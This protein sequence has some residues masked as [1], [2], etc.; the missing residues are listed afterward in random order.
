M[1]KQLIHNGIVIPE[2][3]LPFYLELSIRGKRRQL[4]LRQIE[5]ALAWAR[6]HGTPY[7]EDSTFVC[8]YMQDFSA[9]LGIN[10]PL[11]VDEVDFSPALKIVEAERAAKER[12]TPEEHKAL[13]AERQA[14]REQ[15]KEQHGHATVDGERV[16]LANYV[17][18]P[19][20]I[21]MGRGK[22]PLRGRWK[23][24]PRQS[25]MTLNLSPDASIPPG[26]NGQRSC[27][28][29]SHCGWRA[30]ETSCPASSSMSG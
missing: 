4:S 20:S 30:G 17:A 3:P 27:G 26:A 22:H 24:G 11:T 10:P 6:K 21:F 25:D 1:L 29:Q 19:S 12:L 18:E 15:L 14:K 16:E 28:S 2:I 23:E 5:M 13:T 7:V 9:A 8:N